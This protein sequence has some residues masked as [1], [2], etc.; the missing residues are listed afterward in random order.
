VELLPLTQG[1]IAL[2]DDEDYE[3]LKHYSWYSVRNKNSK[4]YAARMMH[5][6]GWAKQVSLHH[7]VLGYISAPTGR[8]VDHIN[9]N[10]LDCTRNNLRICT[11]AQNLRNKPS[12]KNTRSKYKGVKIVTVKSGLR[13]HA[14]IT[15]EN[16]SYYLG[17]Y[18]DE[19]SAMAAYNVMAVKLHGKFA[20]LNTWNGPS[21]PGQPDPM[22]AQLEKIPHRNLVPYPHDPSERLFYIYKFPPHEKNVRKKRKSKTDPDP[23][24]SRRTD[25]QT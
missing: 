13:Y 20:Y 16:K 7:E 25:P 15:V 12:K 3:R 5:K 9:G 8:V 10:T 1:Y 23:G 6:N 19:Y 4:V 24:G 22:A 18:K 17:S 21:I 14:G 2:V 11:Q